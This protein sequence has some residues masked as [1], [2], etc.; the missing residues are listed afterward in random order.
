MTR[1]AEPPT[2]SVDTRLRTYIVLSTQADAGKTYHVMAMLRN[3][4]SAGVV[5]APFKA[6][7]V[8]SEDEVE[9][10]DG[11]PMSVDV[12]GLAVAARRPLQVCHGPV[13]VVRRDSL[14]GRVFALC[15]AVGD[16]PLAARDTA[17]LTAL[18]AMDLRHLRR[19][20]VDSYRRVTDEAQVVVIEGAGSPTEYAFCAEPADCDLPNIFAAEV[21]AARGVFVARMDRGGG[22][23]GLA[24]MLTYL[25]RGVRSRGV[26]FVA[27][28]CQGDRVFLQQQVQSA[29]RRLGVRCLGLLD[30]IPHSPGLSH[31]AMAELWAGAH[32][33]ELPRLCEVVCA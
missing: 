9:S 19:V 25:P 16:V 29:E 17:V 31:D 6:V 28:S 1:R 2:P 21:S 33:R 4:A 10:V 26:G 23:A 20:I 30:Y 14:R 24:G 7:T 18:G 3:L 12:A 8:V 22:L 27:A 11:H 13:T 15:R 32:R 5:G